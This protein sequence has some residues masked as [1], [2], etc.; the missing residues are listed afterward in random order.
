MI[1][2][3]GCY[4]TSVQLPL[5]PIIQKNLIHIN[6]ITI[7]S[8]SGYSAQEKSKKF[9]HKNLYSS[10]F[11]YNTKNHRHICEIDQQQINQLKSYIFF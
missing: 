11:A 7:D 9:K 5:I 8:K 4:P 2:N 3:P 1:S 10:T 6:N